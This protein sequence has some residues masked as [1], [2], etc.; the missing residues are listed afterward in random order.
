MIN[1]MPWYLA[2]PL[3]TFVMIS[4]LLL[5]KRFGIS[6]N[7]DTLCASTG[8]G[9]KISYFNIDWKKNTWN[10]LFVLGTILGGTLSVTVFDTGYGK[11][12]PATIKKL[13]SIG[14]SEQKNSLLP[15]ELYGEAA[16][17][18]SGLILLLI[19]GF[20]VGFGAR[21][22]GGCTSGHAIS[23]LSNLQAGSL[24]SV[25]GFFIGGLL[26][27]HLILPILL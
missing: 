11:I 18:F 10:L 3:I 6:S 25:I 19:A 2:G 8:I 20:L 7:L 13:N 15:V 22:A 1:P 26:M 5:G 24:V 23:G 4:M 9:S 21:Y 27:T 16:T 17:S 12:S 14:F